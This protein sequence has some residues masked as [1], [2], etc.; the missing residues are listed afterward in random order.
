MNSN[1]WVVKN[2]SRWDD[3]KGFLYG[4]GYKQLCKDRCTMVDFSSL[5]EDGATAITGN[6]FKVVPIDDFLLMIFSGKKETGE[7]LVEE[8]LAVLPESCKN[9]IM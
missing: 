9:E 6:V 7:K 2:V 4:K 5:K 3:F 8:Y 1:S